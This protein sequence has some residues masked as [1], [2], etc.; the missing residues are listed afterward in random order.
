MISSLRPLPR[1]LL[2]LIPFILISLPGCDANPEKSKGGSAAQPPKTTGLYP[3][4]LGEKTVMLK[5]AVTDAEQQ[6]GLMHR[7]DLGRDEGMI[8]VYPS[9]RA[10]NFWMRNTPTPL[11]IGY[12]DAEGVL[13]EIYAMHPFDETTVSSRSKKL[14]YAVEM[15]QGWYAANGIRPGT[16]LDLEAVKAALKDRGF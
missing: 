16:K 3:I 13:R 12:F 11:D 4:R 9:P 7:C 5:F 6:Q 10:L 2:L 8:F 15:H 1:L 14:Q